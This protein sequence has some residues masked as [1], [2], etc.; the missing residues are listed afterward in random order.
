MSGFLLPRQ[1][2]DLLDG[3]V[4]IVRENTS[5]GDTIFSY[6]GLGLFHTL[7]DRRW[8]TLS[9]DENVDVVN[10]SLAKEEARRLLSARPKVIIYY[11][12]PDSYLR[13][14]ELTRR[15]GRRMG[16]RDIIDAVEQLIGSYRLA[17][18]FEGCSPAQKVL[19]YV[20]R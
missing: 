1:M 7:T 14:Q 11:R 19:V 16:Q 5:P 9:G 6:P 13:A 12:E 8:P 4:R 15:D 20:E 18:T 3:T 2:V 10:D 17:G